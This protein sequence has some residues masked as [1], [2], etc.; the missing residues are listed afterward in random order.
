MARR[1]NG[2]GTYRRRKDGRWEARYRSPVDDK[3]HSVYGNTQKAVK[4]KL[5]EIQLKID[6]YKELRGADMLMSEWLDIWLEDYTSNIK[7]ATRYAYASAIRSRIKPAIGDISIR[8]LKTEDIQKM[9]MDIRREGLTPKTIKDIH[10]IVHKCLGQALKLR[11][12]NHNVSEACVLP[13]Q[14]RKEIQVMDEDEIEKFLT[15]I[16]G[17]CCENIFF[18]TLFTGMRQGE[19][20]GL[21]WDC[22]DFETNILRVDKQL[23]R[24]RDGSPIYFGTPKNDKPRYIYA[25]DSVMEVLRAQ[26]AKQLADKKNAGDKWIRQKSPWKD[27]VF[28]D[29][30]GMPIK[31]QLVYKHYKK[32][33]KEMGL[34]HSRFHDLRHSFAVISLQNGDDIKTVQENL[35]HYTASF[36]LQRYAHATNKMKKSSADRM[37]QFI[38]SM[39]I[40]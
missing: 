30:N 25:S 40:N 21:T 33:T 35:G 14:E 19:V 34:E 24:P 6:A 23:L 20:L 27:L 31:H 29:K 13:R 22:V 7:P 28:T 17:D 16:K 37:E 18:V 10:G 8:D 32:I 5:K 9:Y 1:A 12:I 4:D 26:K 2:E 38:R 39:S 15:M 11:Y 3:Q 36:T